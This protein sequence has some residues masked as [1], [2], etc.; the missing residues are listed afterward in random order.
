[1]KSKVVVYTVDEVS[2]KILKLTLDNMINC[3]THIFNLSINKGVF[4]SEL[5]SAKVIPINQSINLCLFIVDCHLNTK[6]KQ[7]KQKN[8]TNIEQYYNRVAAK[9]HQ[10]SPSQPQPQFYI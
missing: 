1:M 9:D 6:Q 8:N 3:L 5:K 10:R 4:P 2:S 7:K